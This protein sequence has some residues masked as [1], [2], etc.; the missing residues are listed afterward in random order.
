MEFKPYV[1]DFERMIDAPRY[2]SSS[3]SHTYDNHEIDLCGG[4]FH[5]VFGASLV[6]H[7]Q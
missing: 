3:M 2:V 5:A 1:R 7:M 4:V 6:L